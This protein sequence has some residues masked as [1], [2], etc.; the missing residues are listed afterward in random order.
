MEDM[1]GAW[2]SH[3]EKMVGKSDRRGPTSFPSRETADTHRYKA[4]AE[5]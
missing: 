4:I 3:L 2:W 5:G 1:P